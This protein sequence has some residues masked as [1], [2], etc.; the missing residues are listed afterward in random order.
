MSHIRE[1]NVQKR[2][3]MT[4]LHRRVMEGG[5]KAKITAALEWEVT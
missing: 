4:E 3:V 2:A 5:L 1:S